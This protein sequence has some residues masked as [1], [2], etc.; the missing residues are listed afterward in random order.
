MNGKK[1]WF[2]PDA[3][4]PERSSGALESHEAICVL[5]CQQDMAILKITLYFEDQDPI[6]EIEVRV[7]GRRTL[8]LKT[9]I[10]EKEGR[11]VPVGVPYAIEVQSSQ[12]IIVQYSRLDT[13]QPELALMSTIAY[14]V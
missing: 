11:R 6:E 14:S 1:S 8:H 9:N 10:L 12:P 7:K 5:N 4:I 2:I 3:Y 13:T